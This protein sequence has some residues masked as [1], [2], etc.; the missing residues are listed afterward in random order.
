[1]GSLIWTFLPLLIAIILFSTTGG[2]RFFQLYPNKTKLLFVW[3][4]LMALSN[5]YPNDISNSPFFFFYTVGLGYGPGYGLGN[6]TATSAFIIG[7]WHI[8]FWMGYTLICLVVT[9]L[10]I[11]LCLW[12]IRPLTLYRPAHNKGT[13]ASNKV[14]VVA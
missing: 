8:S 1:M 2:M 4:P 13:A 12:A 5:T 7:N 6:A 14:N 9:V 10:L 3:N 11:L